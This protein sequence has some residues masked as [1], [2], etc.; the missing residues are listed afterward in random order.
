VPFAL[1][2]L[3]N[4]SAIILPP[5]I[6]SHQF[7]LRA[8]I[9]D[10][11]VFSSTLHFFSKDFSTLIIVY[12][13]STAVCAMAPT[14][15]APDVAPATSKSRGRPKKGEGAVTKAYV[16]TGRPRGRPPSGNGPR[17]PYVPTGRPRGRPKGSGIGKKKMPEAAKKALAASRAAKKVE[18]GKT[19]TTAAKKA[20]KQSE[21]RRKSSRNSLGDANGDA[22]DDA[23]ESG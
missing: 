1:L 9:D 13:R 20:S 11:D 14:S 19:N 4:P 5:T 16:P 22:D 12:R 18:G 10:Y 8:S 23:E 6:A 15:P 2:D 7:H 3:P 17:P 21:D